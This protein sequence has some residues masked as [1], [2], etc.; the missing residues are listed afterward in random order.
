ML[1]KNK[2]TSEDQKPKTKSFQI[3]HTIL[4]GLLLLLEEKR[5][6]PPP[7]WPSWEA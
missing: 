7:V 3:Q 1:I 6:S 2:Q 4:L 5:A